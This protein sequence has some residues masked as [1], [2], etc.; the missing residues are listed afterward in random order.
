ME[1]ILNLDE[2][3][4][5]AETQASLLGHSACGE[6]HRQLA[7]WLKELKWYR[8]TYPNSRSLYSAKN[9]IINIYL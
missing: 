8:E 9:A 3:I 4:K 1:A 2:A 6:E 5:H 7:E